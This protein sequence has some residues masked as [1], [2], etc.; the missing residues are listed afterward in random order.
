MRALDELRASGMEEAISLNGSEI[1]I[2]NTPV[3]GI[4]SE[5]SADAEMNESGFV[6]ASKLRTFVTLRSKI[7]ANTPTIKGT[8]VNIGTK[9]YQIDSITEDAVTLTFG[10]KA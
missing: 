9:K 5:E 8:K 1:T 6:L 7:P 10:L 3:L 2:A 4:L